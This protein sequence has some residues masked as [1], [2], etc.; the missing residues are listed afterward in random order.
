MQFFNGA[1][2]MDI[3]DRE[4]KQL[5]L[6]AAVAA[7]SYTSLNGRKYRDIKQG[8]AYLT[9]FGVIRW[10]TRLYDNKEISKI[11]RKMRIMALDHK[12]C[13]VLS[14]SAYREQS[15]VQWADKV[16]ERDER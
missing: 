6:I 11:L 5:Q 12:N 15:R 9:F 8:D 13:H 4:N 16:R 3:I 7:A 2:T 1:Q 14:E 10:I